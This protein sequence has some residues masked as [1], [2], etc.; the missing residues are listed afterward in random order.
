MVTQA[1]FEVCVGVCV[2]VSAGGLYETP[3]QPGRGRPSEQR[4]PRLRR[5]REAAQP[6][7]SGKCRIAVPKDTCAARM[8]V[9]V[10]RC[11]RHAGVAAL[12]PE[13]GPRAVPS[14]NGKA[15]EKRLMGKSGCCPGAHRPSPD[16]GHLMRVLPWL[17]ACTCPRDLLG[18]GQGLGQCI[19]MM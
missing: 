8:G 14:S 7:G 4:E 16:R 15:R 2:C 13:G 9:N 1:V 3:M 5:G 10:S 11:G 17:P 6:R 18:P 19:L 12:P